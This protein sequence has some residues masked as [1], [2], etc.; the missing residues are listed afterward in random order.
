MV[1]AT[2]QN[3]PSLTVMPIVI[4][5]VT[6]TTTPTVMPIVTPTATPIVAS[7]ITLIASLNLIMLAKRPL[8]YSFIRI[9]TIY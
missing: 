2:G 5:I 4:P 7:T 1:T 9:K 3:R 8:K 6:P